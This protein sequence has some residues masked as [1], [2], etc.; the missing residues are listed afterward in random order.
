MRRP[1]EC[2]HRAGGKSTTDYYLAPEVPG[3]DAD[4]GPTGF[5]DAGGSTKREGAR[6]RIFGYA[7]DGS[8]VR[9]ITSDD[10]E[11]VWR[12]HLA[13]NKAAWYRFENALDLGT[14]AKPAGR[15]NADVADR[16][17]LALDPG[18]RLLR[19]PRASTSV[20]ATAFGG[21]NGILVTC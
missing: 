4:P 11:I 13:N 9:E 19:G 20:D 5:K 16:R 21:T 17:S 12:V 6:F 14:F 2:R 7:A 1:S 8:V 18:S 3:I 15:R 10:A